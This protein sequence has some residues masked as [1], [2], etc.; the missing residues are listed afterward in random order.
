MSWACCS[1][2]CPST[3]NFLAIGY[4]LKRFNGNK[5]SFPVCFLLLM[6]S[7]VLTQLNGLC[8]LLFH[9]SVYCLLRR[10]KWEEFTVVLGICLAL[11]TTLLV[12]FWESESLAFLHYIAKLFSRMSTHCNT[13]YWHVNN[14][15]L[16]VYKIKIWFNG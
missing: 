3:S 1:N 4:D 8:E 12:I 10:C 13:L 14:Y 7:L 5:V 16:N 11:G 9:M 2:I 15:V 6:Y